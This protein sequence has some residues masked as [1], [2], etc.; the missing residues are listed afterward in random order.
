MM[1]T[2][3]VEMSV[4]RLV[5][6]VTFAVSALTCCRNIKGFVLFDA[7]A[8]LFVNHRENGQFRRES[9]EKIGAFHALTVRKAS[10]APRTA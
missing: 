8:S 1:I 7:I 10:S 2:M 6:Q 4:S 5:G 9:T 3:M